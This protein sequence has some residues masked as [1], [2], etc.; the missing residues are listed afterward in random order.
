MDSLTSHTLSPKKT[1]GSQ[2]LCRLGSLHE[3]WSMFPI[4]LMDMGSYRECFY[5]SSVLV[6]LILAAAHM[7]NNYL[8]LVA[9]LP[10]FTPNPEPQT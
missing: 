10:A 4:E 2:N 8:F 3:L 7:S 9:W 5:P 1:R 6:N